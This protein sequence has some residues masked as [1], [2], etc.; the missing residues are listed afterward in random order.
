MELADGLKARGCNLEI[1]TSLWGN[2]QFG[3]RLADRHIPVHRMW[4]GFISVTLSFECIRMTAHQMIHWPELVLGYRRFLREFNPDKVVHTNWQHLLLLW[5]FLR[6]DRDL[7]WL[8]EVVP[9]KPHYRRVFHFLTQRLQCFVPV[10][11]AVARSLAD[12]G[13]AA[14]KIRVIYNGIKVTIPAGAQAAGGQNRFRLGIVGQVA[15]WKGHEDLLEA[16][17]MVAQSHPSAELH[18][19]GRG[20]EEYE[21]FLKR[22]A[23]S[24]GIARS[25][26]WR[27]YV[28]ERAAIYRELDVCAVPSRSSDP[29]PTS[30]IEAA[31]FGLPVVASH[32]GGLP[33]IIADGVTGFLVPPGKPD[34]LAG[35]IN[36]LI[37]EPDTRREM[38]GRAR[39]LAEE[40][41]G[42]GRFLDDFVAILEKD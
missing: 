25:V 40:R 27:G 39:K 35:K 41:F 36:V 3:K 12:I 28:A 42:S 19:F 30:A 7:F 37:E 18:V 23:E 22:K 38:G 14:H 20:T 31:F 26:L 24:L 15:S 17:A 13:I 29:L 10:S 32:R 34:E 1:L 9:N 4:L 6:P 5:P 21:S 33:E 2:G 11:Q 8:H 16:F